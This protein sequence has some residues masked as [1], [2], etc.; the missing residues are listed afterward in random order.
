MKNLFNKWVVINGL[1]R[2]KHGFKFKSGEYYYYSGIRPT[3]DLALQYVD[4][5]RALDV[6][7]GYGA[8]AKIL[9]KKGFEV[10]VTDVNP[11][12]VKHLKKLSKRHEKLKF[13]EEA[14]PQF[15][16]TGLFD[17][18]ICEMVLHFLDRASALKSIDEL[19][20]HTKTGGINV[21]SSYIE[22]KSLRLDSRFKG[23]FQYLLKPKELEKLYEGWEILHNELKGNRIGHESIR[24]I[25]RKK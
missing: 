22:Q 9:L 6:G 5:R 10:T 8:E 11:G 1:S 25:A 3:F 2:G 23:Y 21:I 14:L 12:A 13:I 16:E 24:F 7:A 19:Q 15:S 20:R 17:V 4:G 18:I